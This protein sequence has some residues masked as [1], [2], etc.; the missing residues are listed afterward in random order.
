MNERI[1]KELNGLANKLG[2]SEAEMLEKYNEIA[3]SNNLDLENER[4]QMVALT[5]TRNF[6]RGSL[7]SNTTKRSSGGYG[8][9]AFGF[10]VGS[11]PAR[12]VQEWKR[13]TLISDYNSNPNTVFNEERCAEVVL[14]DAGYE[15]SQVVDGDVQTKVIPQLPNSSIE[16]EENKWIVPLDNIKSF[17]SGDA[18]PRYGKPLP[19]EEFR[20]RVHLIAKK[21]GGDYQYWTFGLKNIAA[22]EWDV[23]PFEWIHLNALFNDDRNACYGIKGR[24]LAS[25]QYNAN[26]DEDDDLYV[27]KL[28]SMEDLLVDC[29]EEYIADLMEIED[30]HSTIMSNPGMKLCITDGIVSS[31]NLTVNEKTGNRVLWIEPAD[32]SYG[33]EEADIPDSTPCWIPANVEI[34]FGVGSD[35]IVIGRTNQT[36]KRDE[37]GNQLEDEWN[38]VSM[39]V[40]G[41]LPRVA[42]GAPNEVVESTDDESLTYW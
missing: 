3:E 20:R 21:D 2:K 39:N 14:T 11:E 38:P 42:L 1:E 5:L 18:N 6:V 34:D 4:Q 30:Y 19:A 41:I 37:D 28:P 22:K 24:T 31:M 27:G 15:K 16:V 8:N 32:A 40:Y 26:L 9:D 35:I 10:V 36:L 12:D 25:L 23:R 7:K 33:F 29:M 13:K 17:M